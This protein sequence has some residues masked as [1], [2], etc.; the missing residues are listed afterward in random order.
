MVVADVREHWS[1]QRLLAAIAD[2]DGDAFRVFYRR[3]LP[4]TVGYL[5]RETRNREVTADLAAEVFAAVLLS[6]RRYR[7]ERETAVPWVLAIARN[8]LGASRRRRRVE[9]RARRRLGLE[10]IE[11]QDSDLERTEALAS[12]RG[13][14]VEMVEQLPE[15]ERQAVQARVVDERAYSEIAVQMRCS[16]LVVRKRVSRGLGRLRAQVERRDG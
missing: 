10:R 6:A 15:D 5:L 3:H 2:R 14:V 9:D 12:E 13:G 4:R 16:E 11:L 7:P 8:T 1:D